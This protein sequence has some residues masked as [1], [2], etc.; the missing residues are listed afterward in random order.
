MLVFFSLLFPPSFLNLRQ[1]DNVTYTA[2]RNSRHQ[3]V[4]DGTLE[5][6]ELMDYRRINEYA[7]HLEL[8]IL[9]KGPPQKLACLCL[10]PGFGDY[11][12]YDGI[13]DV[14]I[15]TR[16]GA[17]YQLYVTGAASLFLDKVQ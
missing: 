9:P 16:P 11:H 12:Q 8:V 1:G 15:W 10:C 6:E 2:G 17:Q 3:W 4:R 7:S 14:G 5:N 13:G